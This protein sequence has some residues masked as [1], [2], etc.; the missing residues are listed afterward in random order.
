MSDNSFAELDSLQ[1]TLNIALDAYREQLQ[2]AS[3]PAPTTL[4]GTPHVLDGS[5]AP[6]TAKIYRARKT[7]LGK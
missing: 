1:N 7:A 6:G 4:Q 3:L 2:S 5:Y